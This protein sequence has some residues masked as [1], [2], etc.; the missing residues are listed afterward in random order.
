VIGLN[1]MQSIKPN[2]IIRQ[3]FIAARSNSLV[4]ETI[5]TQD[6]TKRQR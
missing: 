1:G 4:I 2:K 5:Q 6:N 3:R